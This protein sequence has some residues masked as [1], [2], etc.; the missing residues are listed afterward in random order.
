MCARYAYM[1]NKLQYCGG[2]RNLE[3]FGYGAN[4]QADFGLQML[5]EKFQ[6]LY[7]YLKLIAQSNKIVDPF[8]WQVIEAYW[9]GNQLLEK[10][11]INKLYW[12]FIDALNLKKKLNFSQFENLAGTIN[13]GALPHHNFH[14][15]NI[16]SQICRQEPLATLATINNCIINFGKVKK[17]KKSKL[18]IE[19]REIIFN[20]NKY[21]W[22]SL[23]TKTITYQFLNK[24]FIKNLHINQLISCHWGWACDVLTARQANNLQKYTWLCLNYANQNLNQ[25]S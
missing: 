8:D 14:V 9:L 5:L 19:L 2:K 13:Q 3:L 21:A 15:L 17:I 12:H 20:N 16:Y 10:V 6:T 7:P 24:S 11:Q 18:D 22:S 1:P 23:Q 4:C 25:K